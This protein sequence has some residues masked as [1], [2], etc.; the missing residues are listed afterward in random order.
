[1]GGR[2]LKYLYDKHTPGATILLLIYSAELIKVKVKSHG[3]LSRDSV[4]AYYKDIGVSNIGSYPD[5][6]NCLVHDICNMEA[7]TYALSVFDIT[8]IVKI[9]GSFNVSVSEDIIRTDIDNLV[10]WLKELNEK[11]D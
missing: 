6:R 5:L 1:M 9:A 3:K 8:I 10:L 2:I 7:I 4:D 11:E